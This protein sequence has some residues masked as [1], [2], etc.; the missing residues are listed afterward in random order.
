[1][2]L[3]VF[4]NWL[5]H[6]PQCAPLLLPPP[7]APPYTLW[8]FVCAC[9]CDRGR[10][11]CIGALPYFFSSQRDLFA[12]A[13]CILVLSEAVCSPIYSMVDSGVMSMLGKDHQHLY[14]KQR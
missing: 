11:C 1:M 8:S 3:F 5:T 4:V 10:R 12:A 9:V 6:K 7:P 13:F 2:V 14:G